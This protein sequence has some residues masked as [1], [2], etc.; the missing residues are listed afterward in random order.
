MGGWFNAQQWLG[1]LNPRIADACDH[2]PHLGDVVADVCVGVKRFCDAHGVDPQQ[3][4]P[5]SIVTP[6]GKIIVD[7]FGGTVDGGRI[8]STIPTA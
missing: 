2:T 5:R 4:S 7:L 8:N 1:R 6:D 3:L